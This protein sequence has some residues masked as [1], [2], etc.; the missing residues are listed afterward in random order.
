MPFYLRKSIKVGPIRFNLSKSGVGVSAGI[1]GFRIGSGP[2][3]N[4]VHI[5]RGGIYYRK[6][7]DGGNR[8]Q[9]GQ[10]HYHQYSD[11]PRASTHAALN[12]IASGD[13]EIMEGSD[14]TE[15]LREIREKQRR[16]RATPFVAGFAFVLLIAALL[17][18]AQ[19]WVIAS[20]VVVAALSVV[21]AYE[22]DQLAK[23][24]VLFY[25]FDDQ[26]ESA[27]RQLHECADEI[28]RCAKIWHIN[29]QGQVYD[30][31][32]HA[33]AETLVR[34]K[35]TQF[36]S[37][38]F[39]VIRTNVSTITIKTG[40]RTLCFLPDRVLVFDGREVGAVEYA[41][42]S[43]TVE[44]QQFI[45]NERVPADARVVGRTWQYVNKDGGPDRRFSNNFEIPVCLYER[46]WL[47]SQSGLCEV[48][49]VSR[50][51]VLNRFRSSVLNLSR[52]IRSGSR[53]EEHKID[54]QITCEFGPVTAAILSSTNWVASTARDSVRRIDRG[55][56]KLAGKDK[57]MYRFFQ[58]LFAA[59]AIGAVFAILLAI[60]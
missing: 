60:L 50:V 9:H 10:Q 27:F 25:E 39:G 2:R 49:S 45:E 41:E 14:S 18:S 28:S 24:V 37:E 38:A 47:Q 5:G 56:L 11:S 6:S 32:Y 36:R 29:A 44:E 52:A 19:L 3:G 35:V 8:H 12:T 51:G 55:I 53:N 46:V 43:L 57:F 7:L 33:G 58:I 21:V 26:Q 31:K 42:L 59:A 17:M 40:S 54:R 20:A 48:I 30:Q 16:L 1:K 15:L 34:R 4:Y 22:R 23:S 13:V